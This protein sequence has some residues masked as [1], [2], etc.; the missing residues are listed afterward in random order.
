MSQSILYLNGH[1]KRKVADMEGGF[2]F[3]SL[4]QLI[5]LSDVHKL[6]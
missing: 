4:A 5:N 2:C 3:S 1:M 6:N